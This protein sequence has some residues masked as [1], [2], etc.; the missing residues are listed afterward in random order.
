MPRKATVQTGERYGRLIVVAEAPKRRPRES[1]RWVCICD[2]GGETTTQGGALRRGETQSCGCLMR[3]RVREAK[4]PLIAP[5]ERYGRL[6]VLAETDQ[7]AHKGRIYMC[8]CACGTELVVSN[9]SLRTGHT[10]SCGC[11]ER[12]NSAAKARLLGL[13]HGLAP[14]LARH[15]LYGTWANMIQRCRNPNA[16]GWEYYGGRGIQVCERWHDF[17]N[18]LA[19]MGEKPSSAYSLDRINVN[20]HYE[21]GNCRWATRSEQARN[22]RPMRALPQPVLPL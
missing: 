16:V 21:P 15:P 14:R 4:P 17:A 6:I 1:R 7:R 18:F 11:L 2:C 9:N 19:D 22:K 8:R 12:D 3:Q 13:R 20:G 5:G 10:Q